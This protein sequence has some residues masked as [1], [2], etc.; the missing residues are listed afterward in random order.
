MIV[1]HRFNTGAE[2]ILNAELIKIIESTPDTI[3]T[4]QSN[5]KLLVKETPE[6]IV[7]R[8]V[9]YAR[10]IRRSPLDFL[11]TPMTRTN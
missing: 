4:L 5:E 8:V 1:L 6:Q 11:S 3:L 7:S 10:I 2:F 9:E